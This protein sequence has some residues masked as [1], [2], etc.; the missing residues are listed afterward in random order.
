MIV[1]DTNILSTFAR[2][3]RLDLLFAVAETEIFCLPPTVV[4]EFKVGL[5]KGLV[6][7]QPIIDGLTGGAGYDALDLTAEEKSLADA[8]PASLNAGE[9]E[10]IAVCVKRSE[11]K[12]L[13]ND[14]RARNYC[15]ANRLPC[16]DLKLILRRLWQ[17]SHCSKAEVRA[18]IDEIEKSEPRMVIKGKG[19]I[20][21]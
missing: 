4:K 3:G 12:L 16:L 20:F 13:T 8:L 17:A 18:L 1:A 6:F 10:C 15:Q 9:R 11:A 21:R 19:E 7:L 5:Q 2:V 14:K